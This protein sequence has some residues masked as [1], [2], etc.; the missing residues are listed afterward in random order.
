MEP[1]DLTDR[2]ARLERLLADAPEVADARTAV[3]IA[4]AHLEVGDLEG[5]RYWVHR[6]VDAGDDPAS[7]FRAVRLLDR[8]LA[9]MTADRIPL[10]VAVVGTSTVDQYAGM[11]RLA[12]EARG[13]ETVVRISP[14]GQVAQEILN[15]GSGLYEWQPDLIVLAT[16]SHQ[17]ELPWYSDDPDSEV[18]RETDRWSSLARTAAERSGVPIVFHGFVARP[19]SP[20]GHL[21]GG[22]AGSRRSMIDA[23]NRR[24]GD[25]LP[26]GSAFLDCAAIASGFG[27]ERWFAERYWYGTR[28][29]M[30]L[31]VLPLL[32]RH[33]AALAEAVLGRT[34]K[35][36]VLDLDGTLW[37]GSIGEVG[38]EGI[39][40][41]TGP[42]GEAFAAFQEHVLAL[43]RRGVVLAVC[44]KNDEER[45][46]E[47]FERHPEMRIDLDD[48]ACF[49]ANWDAKP[50]NLVRIANELGIGLDALAFVDDNPAERELVRRVLP[51]VD[52]ITL[53]DEPSGYRRALGRYLGFETVRFTPEDARRTEL[54]RARA[55]AA[56]LR[57]TSEDLPSFWRGL[58]M[59]ATVRPVDETDMPRVAQLVGKTNQFNL[60]TRRHPEA[61]LRGFVGDPDCLFL[62]VRLRDRLVDHGLVAVLVGF[63]REETFEID[64]WLM[65]CRVLGRTLEEAMLADLARRVRARG[66][67]RIVGRY[68]PT[69]RNGLV[70]D[71]YERLGFDLV[72]EAPDGTTTWSLDLH[73][74]LPAGSDFI[75]MEDTRV[76]A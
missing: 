21:A 26:P 48:I 31:D 3:E 27:T 49:V 69:E 58:R 73:E 10:R 65:S 37:G 25:A 60:T 14:Y 63:G 74:R 24:L 1:L 76:D 4:T 34:R 47:P 13:L 68:L 17:L 12:L 8:I 46:R 33:T 38:V 45:A 6:C 42:R 59:T 43:R 15:S 29:A 41:G 28:Q 75:V 61:V 70:A 44:S 71:L 19:E 52:V 23:L 64:T 16:D 57:D 36:L 40:L 35:C 62:S 53:P 5:A 30:G 55:A 20:F 72:D 67:G 22:I 9:A 50:D 54:Y 66:W 32:A 18:R 11:V 7:W 39:E 51:M 2:R 56:R